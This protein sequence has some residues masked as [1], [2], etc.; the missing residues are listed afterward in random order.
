MF[1]DERRRSVW[2]QIRQ[3]DL[4]QFA[5]FLSASLMEQA[6]ATAGRS[7]GAGALNLAT[8]TW[9]A[10]AS[11]F[12]RGKNFAGVL[13]CT[14]K[15]LHDAGQWSGDPSAALLHRPKGRGRRKKERA[16]SGK[17]RSTR[18]RSKHDP[19]G[20]DPNLLSE[21]AFAQARAL[22]P[23]GYWT[24]L[25]LLLGRC[26]QERHGSLLQWGSYRLLALDGSEIQLPGWKALAEHYGRSNNGHGGPVQARMVM[27]QFPLTRLPWRYELTPLQEGERTVAQR[28]LAQLERRDLVLMDKGFFSYGLF[29]QVQNRGAFFA[30]R[31]MRG[32]K[33]RTAHRLGWKDRLVR[34]TPSDRQWK[35]AG[36]P[37]SMTLRGIDYQVKGFRPSAIVTNE[38]NP[39]AISRPQWV[40]LSGS[41]A[42]RRLG[43][44]LY[45]RRWEIEEYQPHYT[46]SA[47]FYRA[48]G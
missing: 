14:L 46:S 35:R 22:M 48:A 23:L 3:H 43:A 38:L 33:L 26:F 11:A 1:T 20:G 4:R 16:R 47:C 41:E 42:G 29:W 6:A 10:V 25:I 17:A 34:W 13:V 12:H 2:N 40:R 18:R 31:L 39:R 7:M 27:P 45:H 36:L 21:E 8:M 30:I 9:L 32:V 44:G 15:L 28:L 5:R 19:H 24:G 37:E